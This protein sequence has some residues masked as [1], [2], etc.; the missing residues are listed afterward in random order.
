MGTEINASASHDGMVQGIA[1]VE[2]ASNDWQNYAITRIRVLAMENPYICSDD[3]WATGL[4]APPEP[5]ALGA[6]FQ[7]AA[8]LGVIASTT[9]FVKTH[10]KARHRAPVQVWKSKLCDDGDVAFEEQ[11]LPSRSGQRA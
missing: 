9:H 5:R 10:Q 3:V 8:R 2:D 6:A 4:E 7:T 1:R 11:Y